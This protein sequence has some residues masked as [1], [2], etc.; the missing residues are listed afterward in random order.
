MRSSTKRSPWAALVAVVVLAGCTPASTRQTPEPTAP[1]SPT[2]AATAAATPTASPQ[3]TGVLPGG[4]FGELTF[5]DEFDGP[6][7]DTTRWYVDPAMDM[8]PDQPWRRNY[9]RE[10][11]YIEDGVLVIRV[12]KE[13]VGYSTAAIVTGD[14][15]QPHPFEQAFGR[16]EARMRFPTQQG[17]W[18]A[19]WLWNVSEGSIGDAGRDGTEIDILEKAYLIDQ[20][21][22][23]L[24]WD[25]YGPEWG[26]AT[27]FVTGMGL[28]DGGWH[29]VR[30]DWYPDQ[31]VFFIDDK[32]TW[33]T[34][35]GGV[36]QVPNFVILSDEIGNFGTGPEAWGV[37]PI[38]DAAL[39]DFFYIDYV[40]VYEYVPPQ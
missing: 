18:C 23:A 16:F 37:G 22:H 15:G 8:G 14:K 31:Y 6:E 34:T 40:R 1:P 2:S 25:G 21:D 39:T 38:E 17:H 27:Q 3:Y 13:E 30:L 32:E 33:R 28:N 4:T 35:D 9:K 7:L 19:F 24:Q 5:F 11:V 10:N 20:V 12:A 36:S 26:T 29:T